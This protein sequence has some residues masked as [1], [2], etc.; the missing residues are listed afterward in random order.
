VTS[1]RII[2][3]G[4]DFDGV[5]TYNP[6]RV[7]RLIISFIKHKILKINKIGFFVPNNFWQRWLYYLIIVIPSA[8]PANG[9]ALLKEMSVLKR[10]KFYLI[11]GRF[12]FVKNNTLAWLRYYGLIKVF[13]N[14]YINDDNEQPHEFKKR[15]IKIEKFDYFIEYNW[16]IV[17]SLNGMNTRTKMFWIFNI[18]DITKKYRYKF[19]Y[20][21]KALEK[22]VGN[23]GAI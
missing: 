23:E 1:K 9:V 20:L 15:I 4:L 7:A 10:F 12:D 16:D 22:I 11:T 18:F 17:Q 13:K 2:K 19:P 6:F 14:I 5:V 3:V 21:G 8:F